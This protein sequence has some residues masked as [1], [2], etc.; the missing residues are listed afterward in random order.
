MQVELRTANWLELKRAIEVVIEE[1]S[2]DTTI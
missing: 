1:G 2:Y